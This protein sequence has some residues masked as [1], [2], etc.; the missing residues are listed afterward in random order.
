MIWYQQNQILS[1]LIILVLKTGIYTCA[2]HE[3]TI[4]TCN[5]PEEN[6]FDSI[7]SVDHIKDLKK[8]CDYLIVLYHEGKE[9]YRYP[10]PYL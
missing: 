2:D 3:F 9:H 5:S 6:P 8:R 1:Y 7:E 4:A 10:S